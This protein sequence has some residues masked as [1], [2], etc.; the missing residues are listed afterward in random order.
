[1]IPGHECSF[2]ALLKLQTAVRDLRLWYPGSGRPPAHRNSHREQ[3]GAYL[4]RIDGSRT[5]SGKIEFHAPFAPSLSCTRQA[6]AGKSISGVTVASTSVA[7]IP[8][9]SRQRFAAS[10]AYRWL[11]SLFQQPGVRGFPPASK[12]TCQS[13]PPSFRDPCWSAT[14]GGHKFRWHRSWRFGPQTDVEREST[15]FSNESEFKKPI[16]TKG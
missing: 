3:L 14:A 9:L 7:T 2:L 1:M 13:F 4:Q 10:T 11:P 12:S 8:L 6:V 15:T 16:V 5:S